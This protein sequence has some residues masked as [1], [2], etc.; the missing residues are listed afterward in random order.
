MLVHFEIQQ[1]SPQIVRI[2][3]GIMLQKIGRTMSARQSAVIL[4]KYHV[5]EV[6]IGIQV[7]IF[8]GLRRSRIILSSTDRA[9]AVLVLQV[10]QFDRVD[11]LL[12]YSNVPIERVIWMR[13]KIKVKN[14]N[15]KWHFG[16]MHG[17]CDVATFWG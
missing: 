9:E 11:F 14:V 3:V 10:R 15:T 16:K 8:R 13:A 17:S 7:R 6:I 4:K 12:R 2:K 5:R 1:R